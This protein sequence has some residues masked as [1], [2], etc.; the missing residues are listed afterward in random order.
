L[1]LTVQAAPF[2]GATK[3]ASVAVAIEV[4][5]ARL[6]FSEQ[7]N[8]T[9]ADSLELSMFALDQRG[10]LHGGAFTQFNLT[11]RP[12][13]YQRVR[14]SIVRLNPRMTLPPGRYQLRVGVRETGASEMGSVFHDL[15]VPDYNATGLAMSGLLITDEAARQQFSPHPDEQLPPGALPAPATSRRTFSQNDVVSMFT[16]IYDTNASRDARR[17]EVVTTLVG[18]GGE[19]AFSSRES[20]SAGATSKDVKSSRI[21]ITKQIAL[22]DV[23]PGR[24]VLRVE[25]RLLGNDAPRVSR[26]T[27]VTVIQ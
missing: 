2:K 9:F 25:A 17:I 16:E 1:T 12:D 11:L 6:N 21:P 26:E 8:K 14:G 13:T 3:Q 5:A 27:P 7:P 22:K 10:R 20:L 18:E 4:D 24:Y 23:R 19:S 15:V